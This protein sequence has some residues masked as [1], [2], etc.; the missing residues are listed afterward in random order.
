MNLKS[1]SLLAFATC[2]LLTAC[3]TGPKLP[4][5]AV[6][7]SASQNEGQVTIQTGQMLI[8]QLERNPTTGY[9]WQLTQ[10]I[11]QAVLMSD[12][13]K[14]FQTASEKATGSNLEMQYLRF[15]AQSRG[16]VRLNLNY[17]QADV[18]PRPDSAHFILD[19][20]VE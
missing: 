6:L 1:L 20:I 2:M 8:L 13:T 19:V 18:G 9:I 14:D 12:G 10:Q 15:V 16:E 4:K 5:N 11:N 17:I 7:V 3:Q